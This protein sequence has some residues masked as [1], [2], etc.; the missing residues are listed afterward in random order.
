MQEMRQAYHARR[1]VA[2]DVLRAAG[3]YQYTPGGAFYLLIDI[4]S[5]GMDSYDFARQLLADQ[6]VAVA[7]GGTF[8]RQSQQQIRISFASSPGN[9]R[10]GVERICKFIQQR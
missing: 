7:P 5:T 4:G 1:D 10:E 9:I 3:L 2:L 6:S 8:G